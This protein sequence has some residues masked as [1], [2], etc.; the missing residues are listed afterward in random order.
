MR[1]SSFPVAVAGSELIASIVCDVA[2]DAE[3]AVY[4]ENPEVE[5]TAIGD[6]VWISAHHDLATA[7]SATD[8]HRHH[9]A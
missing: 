5:V 3:L 6:N 8:T 2:D 9:I 1:G 4:G 7:V